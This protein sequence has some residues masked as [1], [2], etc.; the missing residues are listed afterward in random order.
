MHIF[1]KELLMASGD[2]HG[3]YEWTTPGTYSFTISTAK[4]MRIELVGAGSKYKLS[5]TG[6]YN[7]RVY[8][9]GGGGAAWV[10]YARIPSGTYTIKVGGFVYVPASSSM[11]ITMAAYYKG[12]DSTFGNLLTAGGAAYSTGGTLIVD[13]N[14]EFIRGRIEVNSNGNAATGSDMM[15]TGNPATTYGGESL[16]KGYGRGSDY[17]VDNA[18]T[19]YCRLEW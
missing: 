15:T 16:W 11:G 17:S 14:F 12:D 4:I 9:A 3:L 19:G 13:D 8:M 1:S 6:Y 7:Q 2:L 18:T 5:G 10:G